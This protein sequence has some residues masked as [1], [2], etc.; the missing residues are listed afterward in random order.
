MVGHCIGEE[1]FAKIY[2]IFDTSVMSCFFY[3]KMVKWI[4]LKIDRKKEKGLE[5]TKTRQKDRKTTELNRSHS[6]KCFLR[7]I[8]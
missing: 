6:S 8:P 2:E 7:A 3:K 4:A 5:G 1:R